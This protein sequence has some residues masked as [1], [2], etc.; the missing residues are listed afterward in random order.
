M[1]Y[2]EGRL[3]KEQGSR[4]E[5][6]LRER[7]KDI[8]PDPEADEPADAR[9][10]DALIELAT[11]GGGENATRE[12]LVVHASAEV[13]ARTAP[14]KGPWLAETASGRRLHPEMIRRFAC[15][16]SIEWVRESDG[17]PVGIGRQG[18]Q[19]PPWLE[20]IVRYRDGGECRFPG[21]EQK[22]FLKSHHI[23]HWADGG[24]TALDNLVTLCG[25]H[26][27]SIHEGGWR[28]GGHASGE[29]RFHAPT[30]RAL[31]RASPTASAA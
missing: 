26:H 11:S 2:I 4:L 13:L 22:I 16:A 12:M 23:K 5:E 20:R 8:T 28:I 9:R 10:A 1:L 27:R 19:I 3:G 14:K 25:M 31:A 15:D 29:L 7:A 18:R 17:R 30:G 6:A 21:C 24:P